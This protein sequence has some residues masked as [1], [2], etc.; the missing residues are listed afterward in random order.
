MLYLKLNAF[1]PPP[2]LHVSGI[3]EIF[4]CIS[5]VLSIVSFVL[6]LTRHPVIVLIFNLLQFCRLRTWLSADKA[7]SAVCLLEIMSKRYCLNQFLGCEGLWINYELGI[8]D[9]CFFLTLVLLS[10]DIHCLC[11]QCRSRSVGF[12]SSEEANWSGSA[13][14][15]I[16]YVIL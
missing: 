1:C 16:K 10:P 9:W 11:K 8:K 2:N 14:F 13:L 5:P 7:L 4:F 6:A 12:W 3:M 15:A